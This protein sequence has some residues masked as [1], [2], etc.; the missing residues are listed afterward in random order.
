[1]GGEGAVQCPDLSA[2]SV[3]CTAV[4]QLYL[5]LIELTDKIASIDFACTQDDRVCIYAPVYIYS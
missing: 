4:T 5:Y 2:R 1:M 3:P